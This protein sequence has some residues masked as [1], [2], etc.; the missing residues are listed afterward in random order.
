MKVAMPII[1]A[2]VTTMATVAVDV[3]EGT[4]RGAAVESR[5]LWVSGVL[6]CCMIIIRWI[7]TF[8]ICTS[9]DE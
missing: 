1:V 9:N 4:I 6:W 3:V 2:S 8:T 7:T 5:G